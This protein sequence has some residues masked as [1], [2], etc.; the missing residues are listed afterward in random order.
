MKEQ[1]W[2]GT[3]LSFAS[4]CRG[5]MMA[6]VALAVLSVAGGFVPY[7]GVYQIIRL[8]LER[9]ASW[10]G[11]LF[12]C[13]VCLAGYA[14]KV[15][16]YAL[17]T[18][19]AHVSAYT[20][21]EG[22][23]LQAA[24]RLMGAPLGEVE[25]RPIG[26]MKSTI[27][28]RIEDIEPPLAHM[29]PE[30]SSNILLPLVVVIAM[31]LIDWRMGLALLV[32]I[33]V[34][35][36]P[37]A[38]GMKSYNKN[39]AAYMEANAH[40]NS[41]IVEYVEGIQV[42]KAFS[43]GERSYQK[44]AR[45][46]SS[47][48]EFTMNWYRCTWA[49]MNLCLSI[50]PTTLLGTLPVGVYLYQAGVLDPAQ[51]TLCLMMALGIVSPLMSATAFINSMKSMQFA[52]KDTRELLDLP[53]LSQAEQDVPLDGRAMQLRD[54]SFSYGGQDGKEVLHHLDLTIPQGKFTALVG[55]SGGGKSTIARLAARFW[56]VTSGS[57][58]LGGHDIRE[59]PLKQLSREIS[60]VTQDN[61]LFDC[62]LK[63]NIRLGRPGASDEE[64][65]AAARA[66]RCEE[67]IGRLE[68][69]WDTAAGDAG[70]QLSGGERQR[71]AI[72]RAILKDAPIVILDEATAFTDPE[73]EDKIQRSIMALSKGKTLLV[74]AH[75]LSTIQNAD[76]I[77]VLEEGEIVDRGTQSELLGR[78][79]LYQT[80][81]AAHV[82]AQDWAVTSGKKEEN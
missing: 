82:G 81:W 36:I 40:V 18:M 75:R 58:T 42:V 41:V 80:L 9:Q 13:G 31:F 7:L 30:L 8:F 61:F 21:L 38:F 70:K 76:Q 27:V 23:R 47:F 46:V 68:H 39:Y 63:E 73:N 5:K 25:S 64:V 11:I 33:P 71:I 62:S 48:K 74:I 26:A 66:A 59:L 56:D 20:I 16:G 17:S 77:V 6:S 52:V 67:F 51:V 12:W 44:F 14:V 55:P 1:T 60:F 24:D 2:L 10:E 72:A 4:P 78:C 43:Q 37:M 15:A 57:I 35:L 45:A 79:P 50:L 28:D 32:T 49:S 69:G 19:L 29:I 22:L 53:Q 34:A 3:L 65:F 54:V